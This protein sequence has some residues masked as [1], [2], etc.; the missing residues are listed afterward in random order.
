MKKFFLLAVLIFNFVLIQNPSMAYLQT[1]DDL[2]LE[3]LQKKVELNWIIPED[4]NAKSSVI[5]FTINSDGDVVFTKMLR[6]SGD[7]Y[8]DKSTLMA[9]YKAAPF[10]RFQGDYAAGTNLTFEFFFNSKISIMN[11]VD[12]GIKKDDYT[13]V[14]LIN[15]NSEDINL[16]F[17]MRN[18]SN[19]IKSN[20]GQSVYQND[21]LMITIIN[22]DKKGFVKDLEVVRSS[23]DK[24]FDK[25]A[26]NAINLSAP[27]DSLPD[28][29][30]ADSVQLQFAFFYNAL[31]SVDN[32]QYRTGCCLVGDD[33]DLVHNYQDY[34]KQID[35][36]LAYNLS[37]ARYY[38]NKKVL[39]KLIVDN[40][41]GIVSSEIE[42]SSG[43]KKFDKKIL[44]NVQ[45]CSFPTIPV[46]LNREALLFYD[47]VKT[48]KNKISC[49]SDFEESLAWSGKK[50]LT[51]QCVCENNITPVI[52][53]NLSTQADIKR[54]DGG[55]NELRNVIF[56]PY[57]NY[58]KK[59]I[60]SNWR[61][62]VLDLGKSFVAFF[63]I[64]KDGNLKELSTLKSSGDEK[65]D[66]KGLEAISKSIPFESLPKEFQGDSIAIEF[67][68]GDKAF[69]AKP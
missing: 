27:F 32:N 15:S 37:N 9:I 44:S 39:V 40:K 16:D 53:F 22:V 11:K 8:F 46:S 13:G 34:K 31:R 68:F 5:E 3:R 55:N 54:K 6:S 48:K 7:E 69:R 61:P 66:T 23:G 43:N 10:E 47:F 24:D 14:K 26:L 51:S 21:K 4:K 36:I 45:Q 60:K 64:D 52:K 63:K 35:Q 33:S 41:G 17:Y 42:K 65:F 29:I 1:T 2:Y 19:R 20:W 12:E 62:S 58:L 28:G 57:M 38:R 49:L 50:K 59:K 56:D 25:E 18:F 30:S 67:T